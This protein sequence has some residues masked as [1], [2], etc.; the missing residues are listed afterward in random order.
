M[1][2]PYHKCEI[3]GLNHRPGNCK[4]PGSNGI[5]RFPADRRSEGPSS[6]SRVILTVD[7]TLLTARLDAI[8]EKLDMLIAKREG[9]AG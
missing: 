6:P 3:C 8:G 4:N 7:I 5:G 2:N 1:P 9:P